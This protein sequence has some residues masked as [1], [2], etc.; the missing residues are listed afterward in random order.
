MKGI[1]LILFC[2]VIF[3][4]ATET[5]LKTDDGYADNYTK[6]TYNP[7]GDSY[8]CSINGANGVLIPHENC[9]KFYRCAA[10]KPVSHLI[11]PKV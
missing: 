5:E 11:V 7:S 3:S 1:A 10:G 2:G 9:H 4:H 6:D 8:I